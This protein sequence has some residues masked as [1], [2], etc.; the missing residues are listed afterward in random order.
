MR[1]KP[2]PKFKL[3]FFQLVMN[4]H[5]IVIKVQCIVRRLPSKWDV[6]HLNSSKQGL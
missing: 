5:I 6:E 3:S 2:Q 1:F 4:L